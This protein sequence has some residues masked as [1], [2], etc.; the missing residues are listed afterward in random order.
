MGWVQ[1][2]GGKALIQDLIRLKYGGVGPTISLGGPAL[3][4]IGGPCVIESAAHT[5]RMAIAL[6]GVADRVGLPF[7][8]KSS[9][10]KANRTA[11][12]GF[13]GPGLDAGLE[14]LADVRAEVGVCV[15]TDVH[16]PAQAERA[17][18]VVDLLQ[19]PAFLCRQTDLLVAA[20]RTGRPVN[21]KKGQFQ[22]PWDMRPAL[23]K[24][25]KGGDGGVMLTERGTSFGYNNLVVDLRSLVEL[26]A[27]GVAVCFDATH[28]TQTPGS[29]GSFSGGDRKLAPV[30]ARG[31]VAAGVDAI[32]LEVHD[33]PETALSDA[34]A[35]MHINE[36]EPLLRT[37]AAIHTLKV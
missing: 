24:V 34:A 22:A 18:E 3:V 27:L 23:E 9:F 33:A 37:L 1:Y 26:A 25:R 21:I 29:G 20:G 6:K 30:L 17:A 13:R 8:F 5:H 31:A 4:F 32:F 15:T 11:V 12:D 19:I 2:K 10:D 14:I 16:T 7:I 36:V 35:Q 28:A